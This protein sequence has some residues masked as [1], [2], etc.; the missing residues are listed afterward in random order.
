MDRV[1]EVHISRVAFIKIARDAGEE[2]GG[3]GD[4]ERVFRA[5]LA[6]TFYRRLATPVQHALMTEM[7]VIPLRV[8]QITLFR[9]VKNKCSYVWIYGDP[10]FEIAACQN[11]R[12]SHE[13]L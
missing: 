1:Q 4:G 13:N 8:T 11:T 3:E 6:D 12:V 9:Y 5:L 10:S 7:Q 2:G